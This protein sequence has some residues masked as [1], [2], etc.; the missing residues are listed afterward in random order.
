MGPPK[1]MAII[2]GVAYE[3]GA[4][5]PDGRVLKDIQRDALVLASGTAEERY[6]W[7]PSFRVELRKAAE[8][9]AAP[10]SPADQKKAADAEAQKKTQGQALPTTPENLTPDQALSIMQQMSKQ[11]KRK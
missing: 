8:Q 10:P 4:T 7:L 1:K 11:Q 6:E 3:L 5:L 9:Q 2:G